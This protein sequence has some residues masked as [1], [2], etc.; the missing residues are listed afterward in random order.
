MERAGV[1]GMKLVGEAAAVDAASVV[2]AAAVDAVSVVAVGA[3]LCSSG[4]EQ[5]G[6]HHAHQEILGPESTVMAVVVV[7]GHLLRSLHNNPGSTHQ[8][9]GL[10]A[11]ET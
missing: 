6:V 5:S 11:C 7:V 2:A 9:A 1:V 3:T 10:F 4:E 8:S